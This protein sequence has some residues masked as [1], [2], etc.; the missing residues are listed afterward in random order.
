[1][2][3]TCKS[4]NQTIPTKRVEIIPNVQYCV[5]CSN[6]DKVS[7][8]PIIHHKTGNEIQIV[9]D[10]EA[11]AEFH[12]MASRVGFGTLRG[13]KAG[14]SGGTDVKVSITKRDIFIANADEATFNKLGERVMYIYDLLGRPKA[15]TL[16]REAVTSRLIS[17]SQGSRLTKILNSLDTVKTDTDVSGDKYLP[18]DNLKEKKIVTDE[19]AEVIKFWKR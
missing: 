8:I 9:R 6:E 2:C 16:I 14:K 15:D 5:N 13:L 4:C 19:I 1:M 10:R 12:R 17:S 3:R 18:N 11:A 7:A